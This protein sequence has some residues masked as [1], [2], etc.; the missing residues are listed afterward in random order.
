MTHWLLYVGLSAIAFLSG[1]IDSIAGG[2]GL[3]TVPAYLYAGLPPHAALGTN[4]LSATIGVSQ[5]AV[6]FIKKRIFK[7]QL[8]I[9]TMIASAIGAIIG[10]LLVDLSSTGFLNR[11]IPIILLVIVLYLMLAPNKKITTTSNVRK[12][13]ITPMTGGIIG[14]YD[15]FLGPGTGAFWVTVLHKFLHFDLLEATAITKLMNFIS[16]FFSLLVFMIAGHIHYP[17]GM[18]MA[19]FLWLGSHLGAHSAIRFGS[20]L[21]RPLFLSVVTIM[22]VHLLWIQFFS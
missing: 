10:T 17:L 1:F 14:F 7:P 12:P 3:L 8:W 4:K 19:I 20:K 2:G 11:A 13:W 15:G 22:L 21:I 6:V 16:N 5:A 9:A 18:M